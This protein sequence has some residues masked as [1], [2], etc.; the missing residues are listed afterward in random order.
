MPDIADNRAVPL[1]AA[2]DYWR[3]QK[4][5]NLYGIHGVDIEGLR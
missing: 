1:W 4:S 2:H 5:F 3:Y